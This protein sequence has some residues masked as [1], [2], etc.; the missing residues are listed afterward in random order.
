MVEINTERNS[1]MTEQAVE[2]SIT[3]KVNG[4]VI[5]YMRKVAIP[6]LES[7]ISQV[8]QE[9]GNKI[10]LAGIEGLDRDIRKSVPV[11][12]RNIGTEER[13]I[14]SSMGWIRYQRHIYQDDQGRRRKPVDE[15]L[16]VERYGRDSQRVREM[17]AYLACE[18]TYRRA[19]S[20][21]S[22][23][24][25]RE[26]SHSSI[27][28]M[29][30]QVGNRIADGEE[31]ERSRVFEAGAA[32]PKGK[33]KAEVLYGESD[34]VWLHLQRE[35]RRSVEVRVATLY[36]GKKSLGKNRYRLADKCSIITLGLSGEAWQEQVLKAAHRYYDLDQTKVLISGG[37]GNQWVRRTFQRIGLPQEFVLD[38]FH[39]SRAA[40]RAIGDRAEAQEMVM[41]LRQKGFPAVHQ[42][43]KQRIEQA[44]G[45][46]KVKLKQFYQY[47][48]C[49]QDGLLDL[50]HRG[51]SSQ[52]GNLGAIEGNVDKL[53]IHRMKGRGCCWKLHGARAMLA[54]CQNREALKQLAFHYKPLETP[55]QKKYRDVKSIDRSDKLCGGMPVFI[56]PDQDKPWVKELYRYV[57]FH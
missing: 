21:M 24:M 26:V 44:S 19:A 45:K 23:L 10:F 6:E 20:Q 46:E 35:K 57:H 34:G 48:H 39:L 36:S 2:L 18:G 29:V 56:G 53:V 16:G 37:D 43:L 49:Q 28:R 32:I 13:S 1:P 22:W 17:G 41:T 51:Y 42:E 11:G 9:M 40:R 47:I 55:L 54:L 8:V 3:V 4:E 50:S 27:Q 52:L 31:A 12:W 5:Q 7:G 30:W 14:L 38:R 33:V 15:I 25:K